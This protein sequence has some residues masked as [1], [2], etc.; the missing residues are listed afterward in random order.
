MHSFGN[1]GLFDPRLNFVSFHYRLP[2]L[3]FIGV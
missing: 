2:N 3:I 1:R